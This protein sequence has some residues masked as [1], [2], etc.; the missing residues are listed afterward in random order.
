M[1][2]TAVV[3]KTGMTGHAYDPA[4]ETLELSFKGKKEGDP[5]RVYHYTEFKPEHWEAFQAAESKGSHFIK[6]VKPKFACKKLEAQQ[7][8]AV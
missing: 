7:A 2:R 8:P 5:D 6:V 3:S 1:Q 4:T